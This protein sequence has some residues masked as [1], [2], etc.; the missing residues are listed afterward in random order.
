MSNILAFSRFH[1]P[2]SNLHRLI[3]RPPN[4][5]HFDK[6]LDHRYTN[7]RKK[8]TTG[9]Q[10]AA[11]AWAGYPSDWIPQ[12]PPTTRYNLDLMTFPKPSLITSAVHKS[13]AIYV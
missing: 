13:N 8:D 1:R 5:E 10:E 12:A 9:N 11:F 3:L 7:L 2:L 4:Q 6:H